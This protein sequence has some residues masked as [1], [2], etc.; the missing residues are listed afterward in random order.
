[1]NRHVALSNGSYLTTLSA[2][3]GG[4]AQLGE[5]QLTRWRQ[6]L[7]TDADGWFLYVRDLDSGALWSAG[8]LPVRQSTDRYTAQMGVDRAVI[9]RE[10]AQVVVRT[11]VVVARDANLECRRYTI[12]NTGSTHRRLQLTTYAEVA[13]ATADAD[14]GHPAFSKLF[15]QT[16]YLP[17]LGAIVASRRPREAD[18]RP[19]HLIHA[20]L[21]PQAISGHALELET[22]RLR[23]IGRGRTTANP[24]ALDAGHALSGTTGDVLDPVMALRGVLELPAGS[25]ARVHALL[26][27][28]YD[29]DAL[30]ELIEHTSRDDAATL[31]RHRGDLPAAEPVTFAPPP[32]FHPAPRV[33]ASAPT[34]EPLQYF[35]G[36]G[37]FTTDGTEYVIRLDSRADGLAWPPL[38][39]AN[40]VASEAAGF[41]AT[42]AGPGFTW[43]GNSRL[44][45]LTPW[46]NDPVTD[47][48]GEAIYLRDDDRGEF[49]SPT[50][51]PVPGSGAYE[52]RHGF[53]ST[54]WRHESAGLIQEVTAFVAHG[55]PVKVMRI[56]VTNPGVV[57]RRL[58]LICYA[59]WVLGGDRREAR[60]EV[61]TS[62]DAESRTLL[63]TRPANPS[64]PNAVAFA[65]VTGPGSDAVAF[66]SD[67]AEFLG[68]HGSITAPRA[69]AMP[70]PLAGRTGDDIDPCAAFQLAVSIAP[71]ETAE[72]AF[73]IGQGDDRA[74]AL[75]V[76]GTIAGPN[77]VARALAAAQGYWT[78]LVARVQVDTP[79]PAMNL[80]LNGWL[81]YQNVGCRIW[82]RSAFYQSG[83]A[84]GFRDQ[85]Q[86]S[87]AVVYL[88]PAMMRDQLLR[89]AA[90]QFVEGDVLHWWHPPASVGI[91][92][93]FADDLVWLPYLLG[94]YLDATG[95]MSILDIEL[96][97]LD[98][99]PVPEDEDEI[100]VEPVV[101]GESGSVYEHCCRALDRSLTS[102]AHGLPLIGS[103]DWNDGMNR[104]GWLGGG[105][106]VWM[107]FFLYLTLER[108]IRTCRDRG[109]DARAERYRE[110]RAS[111]QS[112]LDHAGWDGAWYRRAYYDNGEPLGSAG[113]DECRI[114][115]I[116]QAW[117]VM[118]GAASPERARQALD[119]M[120]A[121]L[122]DERA[123]LIRLLTPP[124]DTTPNDPGYIKGYLPGVREN[125]GQYTHAALWAI[126]ALAEAGRTGR[127]FTLFEMITPV[128]RG[129]SAGAIATYM[130][131]PYVVAADVYGV[132]PHVGRGGWS[133]YTGSAGWMFRVGLESLLGVTVSAG[134]TLVLRPRIPEDWPGYTV[135]LRP[136]GTG[137]MC[138]VE[139]ARTDGV[140][141]ARSEGRQWMLEDGALRLPLP[142][143]GVRHFTVDLGHDLDTG[144]RPRPV[145]GAAQ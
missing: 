55:A 50:P 44:N 79:S 114:D 74:S 26:A 22:D 72:W 31:F 36:F 42:E 32:V 9:T 59:E 14:A 94:H 48:Q 87:S 63:A 66:T 25:T 84:F 120:E 134:T 145:E 122:V 112:A 37:G 132:P 117:A 41:V 128:V 139:V 143:S 109:D 123:G 19:L 1:M 64:Y 125:G 67:R 33:E 116:A 105:E 45:R 60:G 99:P 135:R 20:L 115:L 52:V 80:M 127:A 11:D 89:N 138:V 43:T 110:F 62:W 83:G 131:E 126:R 88:A 58:T 53:G 54:T 98:A 69:V 111:L 68:H 100:L 12:T 90:H 46:S 23:F 142:E 5:L 29:R 24:I 91:R 61:S 93:H 137:A 121:H 82:A 10:D 70:G 107:G 85:L 49:W 21:V 56:R 113:G 57:A 129:A 17:S 28:G 40:V 15:I 104:V 16:A 101:S 39:W 77:Q 140:T 78:D 102:G 2:A 65:T 86:D 7:T 95:D 3:G 106:S 27:G 35:N 141:M 118:S 38:P 18:E 73:A 130:T 96:P 76:R 34:T 108:F 119:A 75:H 47:P 97:F 13:L 133:W 144:Y 8:Y 124:F 71:G 51:A 136:P 6:D 81:T 92:T 4:G 30:V 103:G